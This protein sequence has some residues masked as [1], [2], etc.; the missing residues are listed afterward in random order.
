MCGSAGLDMK[1][2]PDRLTARTLSQSSSV[3]LSTVLSLVMPALLTRMSSRPWRSMTS[4]TCAGSPP[5]SR[6]CPGGSMPSRRTPVELLAEA[7]GAPRLSRAVA[8]GDGRALRGQAV[9]DRGADAAGAA[10][11]ERDAARRACRRSAAGCSAAVRLGCRAHGSPL[12]GVVSAVGALGEPLG[13]VRPDLACAPST[14]PSG[15]C[16]RRGGRSA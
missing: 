15:R 4:C 9:A 14:R 13:E 16:G 12:L 10:G 5:R 2:A 8:G 1:N 7:L 11:D 3:I 6:R